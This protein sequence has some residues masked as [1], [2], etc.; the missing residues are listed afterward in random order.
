MAALRSF[1][2]AQG[3]GAR[4]ELRAAAK[5]GGLVGVSA[6]VGAAA[7]AVVLAGGLATLVVAGALTATPAAAVVG[8]PPAPEGGGACED[9]GWSWVG[10]FSGTREDPMNDWRRP[11][12]L[13]ACFPNEYTC[14]R[15]VNSV[16]TWAEAPGLM[17]CER[18]GR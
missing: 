15:W 14:R 9:G 2:A 12:F 1:W 7:R 17:R 5:A 3:R 16:Q 6:A 18:L 13:R 10:T 11:V 8:H 4:G